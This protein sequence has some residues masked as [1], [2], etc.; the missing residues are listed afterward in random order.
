M[1]SAQRRT[2][3][4]DGTVLAVYVVLALVLTYPLITNIQ[5]HVPGQ[6]VDDPA[7]TWSLWW[8]KY[9]LLNLGTSPLSTDYLFYPVGI[10]LVAYT[11]T[12]LNGVIS[13]PLQSI[14]GVIVAT[15]LVI[16]FALVAS[17]YGAF[18]LTREILARHNSDS[19]FAAALAGAFYAFGA[20][21]VLYTDAT[22]MLLS[23]EW[24]P[25]YALYLIRLDQKP[26]R[27]GAVAGLFLLLTAW[28]D[29]TLAMFLAILT[30][31]YPI[32]LLIV[33][34]AAVSTAARNL[35]ALGSVTTVGVSPL[36]L[37][38]LADTQRFGYYLA[39]SL[40]RVQIFSAE[41]ISFFVPSAQHPLLGAWASRLTNANT[42]Y[43]FI[44]YAVLILA[45]IGV[46]AFRRSRAARL[47]GALAIFFALLMLGPTLV[48]GGQS[49]GIRLP[50]A[51]LRAIPFLNANRY[52]VR[53]NVMLMLALTPLVA[54]GAA[55]LW[56]ARR[57]MLALGG[58]IV[59]LAFE[60]LVIPIPLSDLRV[61]AIFQTIRDAP[62]DFAV[63]D[64]P[65]G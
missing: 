25:F 47:W 14:F 33:N 16:Y 28:T 5:T 56:R 2:L 50:F 58:L 31:L 40:G 65:L 63:L 7:Q 52:P 27:N 46:R 29:L 15:N 38:L 61:P 42:R 49:T 10:N 23:N 11:P 64:L 43:A 32:Y 9:S 41:P 22:Y 12:F 19:D 13:I 60:Q 57:G 62:G 26:W 6:G 4:R 53:F 51:A 8:I 30:A 36:A 44:G 34:R 45:A 39:A 35:A 24:I 21:H 59:L 37:N 18:L 54:L 55:R 1:T 48:V 3:R 17:G 20:W